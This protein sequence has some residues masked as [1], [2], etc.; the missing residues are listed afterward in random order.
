RYCEAMTNRY[1]L[2]SD[3]LVV[4]LGSND[5]YLLQYFKALG[6]GVLGIEPARNVALAARSRG[7]ETI[8]EFFGVELAQDL[9]ARGIQADAI[10]GANV[11]AQVP[12]LNDFV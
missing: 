9:V 11:L 1:G 3:S 4:E 2:S 7:I 10:C 6:I 8:D 5:G 12:D